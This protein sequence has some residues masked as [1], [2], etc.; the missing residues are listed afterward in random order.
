MRVRVSKLVVPG[1]TQYAQKERSKAVF[2][3]IQIAEIHTFY[4]SCGY[5]VL[6]TMP[7]VI[8]KRLL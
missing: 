6:Y 5:L 7:M 4:L 1:N 8:S 3:K 2:L